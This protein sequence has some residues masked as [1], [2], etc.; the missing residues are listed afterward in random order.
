MFKDNFTMHKTEAQ[1]VL[2][3]ILY[4]NQSFVLLVQLLVNSSKVAANDLVAPTARDKP[5][6]G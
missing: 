3:G 5:L 6:T 4:L 1:I 2:Y